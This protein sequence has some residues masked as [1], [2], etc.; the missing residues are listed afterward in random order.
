MAAEINPSTLHAQ[1]MPRLVN[2]C[3]RLVHIAH[4]KSKTETYWRQQT[5]EMLQRARFASTC[6][7]QEHWLPASGMCRLDS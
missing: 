2:T 5:A 4:R 6:L 3:D 1:L 7:Q